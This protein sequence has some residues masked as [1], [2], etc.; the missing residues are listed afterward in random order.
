MKIVIVGAGAVGSY[1]AERLSLEGQDVVVVESD[2]VKAAELQA[3]VDCLVVVGNGANKQ[4]LEE[5]GLQ[6]ADL[7]IAVTNSDSINVLAAHAGE[8]LGVPRKIARVED[9]ELRDEAMELGVDFFVDP[10]QALARELLLMVQQGGVSE[11]IEFATGQLV[12]VGGFISEDAPVVGKTLAELRTKVT[13]WNWLVVALIR[14][15]ETIIARGE[16]KVEARDHVLL[17]AKAKYI[18]EAFKLLGLRENPAKNVMILGSTRLAQLTSEELAVNGI[19]T[20]LI[21]EDAERCKLIAREHAKVICVQ[22]DPTDPKLLRSEGIENVDA[23]LALT[24]W[25]EVNILGSAIAKSLG[26]KITVAR[27]H[28]ND[29][30]SMLPGFGIDAAVSS[31]LA[32]ANEILRFVRRG[33]VHSVVTFQD[34]DA[35]AIEI[36]VDAKSPTLGKSLSEIGLSRS[37]IVGGIA[38]GKKAFVP[39]GETV[40]EPGDRL[41]VIALPEGIA[42]VER[43]FA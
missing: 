19:H 35:E 12:L 13:G 38:R 6:D 26:A 42:E 17:M 43:L 28:R 21:D 3:Q 24:G 31:R 8:T 37:L 18:Q 7:L 33:L 30:V 22:G 16:T 2:P 4:T 5:A 36:Q 9:P 32:A 41:I 25:D 29:L 39:R 40:I 11:V 23:V 14:G 1:L 27:F 10:G 15:G 34:S 20:I